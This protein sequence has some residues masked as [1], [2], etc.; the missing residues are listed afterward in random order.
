MTKIQFISQKQVVLIKV[1]LMVPK[2]KY[3]YQLI[4]VYILSLHR[5]TDTLSSG[6]NH[7]VPQSMLSETV[8]STLSTKQ[9]PFLL[10]CARILRLSVRIQSAFITNTY[11]MGIMIPAMCPGLF[12]RS[13]SV[14]FSVPCD[15]EMIPDVAKS[16][17]ADMIQTTGFR[18]K[19][20]P[21]RRSTAM[22]DNQCD[23]SHRPTYSF[24]FR[25][26]LR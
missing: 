4:L 3:P 23:R 16:A 7:D 8:F 18:R 21:L 5:S 13:S 19:G 15:I 26:L 2:E 9:S 24:V 14:D 17:M 10:Q 11:R 20:F 1:F 25:T 12:K 6:S 22:N